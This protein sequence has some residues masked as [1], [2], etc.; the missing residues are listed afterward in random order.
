MIG[1]EEADLHVVIDDPLQRHPPGRDP[2]QV[3]DLFGDDDLT[4]LSH[5]VWQSMTRGS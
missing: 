4:L 2:E 1:R 5:Y 3:A